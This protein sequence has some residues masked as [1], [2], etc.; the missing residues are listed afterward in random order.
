M[1]IIAQPY[2]SK[3]LFSQDQEMERVSKNMKK[4]MSLSATTNPI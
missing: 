2:E 3:L 4:L 1:E